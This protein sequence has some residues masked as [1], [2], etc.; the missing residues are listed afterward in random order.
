LYSYEAAAGWMSAAGLMS[1]RRVDS[2]LLPGTS[3][4]IG[5]RA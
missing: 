5:S 3:L 4:V 2:P 1:V